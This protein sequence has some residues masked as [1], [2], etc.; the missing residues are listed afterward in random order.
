MD[1]LQQFFT[2][3]SDKLAFRKAPEGT[4]FSILNKRAQKRR[5]KKV[6]CTM[7]GLFIGLVFLAV[8]SNPRSVGP[9]NKGSITADRKETTGEIRH[10]PGKPRG[11][12][13]VTIS[14]AGTVPVSKQFQ[15]EKSSN[16]QSAGYRLMTKIS[17][18]P[19]Y[20]VPASYFDEFRLT[21][22]MM[23]GDKQVIRELLLTTKNNSALKKELYKINLLQEELLKTLYA[24]IIK[25]NTY[26]EHRDRGIDSTPEYIDW[27]PKID[28]K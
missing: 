8:F 28:S 17:R 12:N 3:N 5:Q 2:D 27:L 25:M 21:H 11:N 16:T 26:R 20:A 4:L 7:G 10:L 19:I 18:T 23:Q 24:E 6:L 1:N 22:E 9:P 13:P 14:G 15:A